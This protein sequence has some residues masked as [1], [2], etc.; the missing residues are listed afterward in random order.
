ML[1]SRQQH[2]R[3]AHGFLAMCQSRVPKF[4][5]SRFS[6]YRQRGSGDTTLPDSEF[7]IPGTCRPSQALPENHQL[8]FVTPVTQ[9]SPTHLTE[10][11]M[12]GRGHTGWP[13]SPLRAKEFPCRVQRFIFSLSFLSPLIPEAK[14]TTQGTQHSTR[15]PIRVGSLCIGCVF[16]AL[17]LSFLY[18]PPSQIPVPDL[19]C[20][21]MHNAGNA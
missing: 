1:D 6:L 19:K 12:S 16:P 8:S 17:V 11:S 7:L 13:P 14:Y 18:P 5:I 21:T 15:D 20:G 9:D 4:Q 3:I 10:A 2:W